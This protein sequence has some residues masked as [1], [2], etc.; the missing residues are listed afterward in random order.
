MTDWRPL[1][2]KD[3]GRVVTGKTPPTAITEL[4]DGAELFVS[5]KDL[6]WDQY[7]VYETETR[8]SEKALAKF[9]N[10]VLPQNSVM[11]TSLSFA[12]G[13]MGIVSRPSLTNQQIT[14]IIVN[15][16]HDFRFVFYLLKAYSPI[17]FSY[18]S[19]ID[20][21]IV[22]KSVFEGIGVVCP[23]ISEQRKIAAILSAYDDLI[24]NNQ[25]RIALLEHMAEEI[26][27]EWFVRLRFPGYEHVKFEKGIPRGWEFDVAAHFFGHVKGKSYGGDELSENSDHMPFITLKSCNYSARF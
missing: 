5:P 22:P 18:N 12:F 23:P 19:G 27:R 1:K 4:F 6:N 17:I 26:Y 14:S 10:Q 21:P 8:V 7:Y 13:K 3:L 24:A 25:R 15:K 2:I 9:K 20:T 11:F 16:D